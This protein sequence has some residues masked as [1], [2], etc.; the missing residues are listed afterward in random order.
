MKRSKLSE[1]LDPG[2]VSSP[3]FQE[4]ITHRSAGSR[5]NERLEYLGDSVL[6][7]II[8]EFLF[9]QFGRATEGD[10]SRLRASLV[11]R[12]T[13]ASVA[14]EYSLGEIIILGEGELKSGGHRR[15]S[16]LADALEA[17]VGA[18]YLVKGPA[19]AGALVRALYGDRLDKL[20]TP[21][22]SK[23]HK[24]RLQE[25]MQS[26]GESLPEYE[27]V[28]VSGQAHDRCFRVACRLVDLELETTG[29]GSSR[30]KAEQAAA[31]A[32]LDRLTKNGKS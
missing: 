32:A 16:I 2:V 9:Q 12:T 31:R 6:Q 13:L 23:D 14:K 15:E 8:T 27:L 26:H 11:N 22:Q 25:L 1:L 30:K 28:E 10:L 24:T 7:L 29:E 5:N 18:A 21:E 3:L 17:I 20:P 19:Y 4:A